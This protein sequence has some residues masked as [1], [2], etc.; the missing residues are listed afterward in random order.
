MTEQLTLSIYEQSEAE[1]YQRAI[2]QPL[3]AKVERAVGL[4]RMWEAKA[5]RMSPAGYYVAFSGGKDSCVIKELAKMA[6]VRFTAHYNQT[7]IDPPELIA[8]LRQQHP[9]VQWE[10]QN[11]TRRGFFE[12][13]ARWGLPTARGRWCCKLFKEGGGKGRLR[14][15]GVR[16]EESARRKRLWKEVQTKLDGEFVAPIVYWTDADVWQFIRSRGVPYCKLYD[17]GI[18]RLGCIGCPMQ[19]LRKMNA[20]FERFPKY[21]AAY[22]AAAYRFYA[23]RKQRIADGTYQGNIAAANMFAT[24]EEYWLHW[25]RQVSRQPKQQQCV[26]SQMVEQMGGVTADENTELENMEVL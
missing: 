5:L 20:Q 14:V 1:L 17:E 13:V 22:R 15:V 12:M 26:Y 16:A 11:K 18:D 9:D 3:A 4:L 7:T 8:F 10:W 24:P 6:G 2:N 19:T 23:R 25:R 21:E